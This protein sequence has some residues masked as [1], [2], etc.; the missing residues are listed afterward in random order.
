MQKVKNKMEN[1]SD[2]QFIIVQAAIETNKQEI[3]SN[4]TQDDPRSEERRVIL[5]K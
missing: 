1:E 4:N 5:G 3:K 2:E